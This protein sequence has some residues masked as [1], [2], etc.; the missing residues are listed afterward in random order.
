MTVKVP[1]SAGSAVVVVSAV[2]VGAAVV[3][4]AVVAGATVVVGTSVSLVDE[5]PS[6]EPQPA[7]S[8]TPAAVKSTKAL[9]IGSPFSI[10]SAVPVAGFEAVVPPMAQVVTKDPWPPSQRAR[11]AGYPRRFEDFFP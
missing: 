11:G 8:S 10:T 5:L 4:A 1:S 6:S 3:A 2:V 7:T 9:R